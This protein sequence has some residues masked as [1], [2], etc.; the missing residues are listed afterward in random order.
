MDPPISLNCLEEVIQRQRD[1]LMR[2]ITDE[3]WILLR[4]VAQEKQVKG[5]EE[6]QI[7]VRSMFVFEYQDKQGGWFGVNPIFLEAKQLE[8][9]GENLVLNIVDTLK[10]RDLNI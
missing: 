1:V 8:S 9:P 4:Q 7:L 3:E 5:V 6:Y 10:S 2:A